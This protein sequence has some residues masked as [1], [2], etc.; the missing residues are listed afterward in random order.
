MLCIKRMRQAPNLIRVVSNQRCVIVWS[1]T[2]N[3]MWIAHMVNVVF[4]TR[5]L[6]LESGNYSLSVKKRSLSHFPSI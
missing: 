3:V 4:L 2:I 1:A 5:F 6:L